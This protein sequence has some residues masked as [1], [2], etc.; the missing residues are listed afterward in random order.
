MGYLI[1]TPKQK[2]YEIREYRPRMGA[3]LVRLNTKF[4]VIYGKFSQVLS[5]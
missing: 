3:S 4:S 5:L 1:L 2:F